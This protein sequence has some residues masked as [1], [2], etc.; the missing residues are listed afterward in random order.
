MKTILFAAVAAASLSATPAFAQNGA[1]TRIEISTAGLD[2]TTAQGRATLDLRVLH[3]AR[4]ACGRHPPP[5]PEPAQARSLLR[6]AVSTPRVELLPLSSI[7]SLASNGPFP[8]PDSPKIPGVSIA[9]VAMSL[10]SPNS[11]G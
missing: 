11:A 10:V 3:A 1:P 2:L 8:T 4:T 5:G 9:T 7:P 6:T